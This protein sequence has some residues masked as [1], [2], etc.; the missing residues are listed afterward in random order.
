MPGFWESAAPVTDSLPSPAPISASVLRRLR[1]LATDVARAADVGHAVTTLRAGLTSTL[2]PQV[3]VR[4]RH[5]TLVIP[6][7]A[8]TGT[9]PAD[10]TTQA[11]TR[12]ALGAF[13]GTQI[14]LDLPG[15]WGRPRERLALDELRHLFTAALE[16]PAARAEAARADQVATAAYAFSRQLS[17]TEHPDRL[18]ALILETMAGAVQAEQAS[19]AT[20]EDSASTIRVATTHGYPSVL[21]DHLRIPPG[22]GILGRVFEGKEALLVEDVASL[23]EHQPRRRYRTPSFLALPLLAHGEVLGV[24]SLADKRS[25]ESFTRADLTAAR[26]LAAPAALALRGDRLAQQARVLSHAATVDPLTGLFNRRYFAT[27]IEE[28]IERARRHTLDLSLLLADVDDFKRLND[29]L[30]HLVGDYL[31]KQIADVLRRSVRVFDVCT[32]FGGEEFAI[33]MPGTGLASALVVAERIRSR[34]EQASR[35]V[36]PL[37]AHLRITVSLGLAV[38]ASDPTPQELIA[39]ADRGLY[40]AKADGKNCVRVES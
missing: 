5:T 12:V 16:A 34:V 37:P 21:V 3:R 23:G 38:L 26:A 1:R 17:D 4:D 27:R 15:P 7:P 8:D 22:R 29:E 39:R 35:D 11:W 2:G 19:L 10:D 13:C 30:G 9:A 14:D 36:G 33:L 18:R 6:P 24:V 25:G 20:L 40:R 32:R 28:E 31:L